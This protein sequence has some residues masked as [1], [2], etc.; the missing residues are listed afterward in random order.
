MV[1]AEIGSRL[2]AALRKMTDATII[3]EDVIL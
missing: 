2:S 1:L 3:D